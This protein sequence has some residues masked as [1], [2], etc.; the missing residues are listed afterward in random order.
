MKQIL[1]RIPDDLLK[2]IDKHVL[3]MR[4]DMPGVSVSRTDA[5]RQMLLAEKSR[6]ES[7]K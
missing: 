1:I 2:W 7:L 6:L 3:E 4:R 5:I